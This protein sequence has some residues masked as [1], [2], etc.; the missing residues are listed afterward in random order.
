VEAY[1]NIH[2]NIRFVC[3]KEEDGKCACMERVEL[4]K[5]RRIYKGTPRQRP[6]ISPD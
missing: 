6:W 2:K 4:Y 5:A 1:K 3:W